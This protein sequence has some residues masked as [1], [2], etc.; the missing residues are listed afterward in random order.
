MTLLVWT[1]V[2]WLLATAGTT[3]WYARAFRRSECTPRCH[4]DRRLRQ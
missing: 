3:L 2:A 4:D 1:L